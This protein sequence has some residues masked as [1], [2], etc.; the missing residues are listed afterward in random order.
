M[1]DVLDVIAQNGAWLADNPGGDVPRYLGMH[2]FTIGDA[3]GER[4]VHSY[5]QWL[6]QRAWAHFHDLAGE[7]RQAAADLLGQVGGL[8]ALERDIPVW[9]ERKAGQLE[10]VAGERPA[11]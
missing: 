1:P 4:F 2:A 11:A 7:A 3:Q 8:D 10:L 6:F 9:L 5:A